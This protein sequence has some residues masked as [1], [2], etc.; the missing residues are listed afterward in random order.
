VQGCQVVKHRYS[1]SYMFAPVLPKDSGNGKV[2]YVTVFGSVFLRGVITG[3]MC[4]TNA[5]D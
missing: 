3:V 4:F 5:P 1:K 2:L